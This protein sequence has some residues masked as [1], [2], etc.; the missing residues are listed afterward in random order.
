ML[1]G[2]VSALLITVQATAV[3]PSPPAAGPPGQ[4]VVGA[5]VH[6][7]LPTDP[8]QCVPAL[9][10]AFSFLTALA[11]WRNARNSGRAVEASRR[12]A[13]ANLL[14]V[15]MRDFAS[16]EFRKGITWFR[17]FRQ[18][19]RHRDGF[20]ADYVERQRNNDANADELDA[21]RRRLTN[22]FHSLSTFCEHD[23]LERR[24]VADAFGRYTLEF[25]VNVVDPIDQAHT[26]QILAQRH[27]DRSRRF[28]D[29]FL[30]DPTLFPPG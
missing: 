30:R 29:A 13:N 11:A 17:R 3:T 28:F 23:L 15:L 22:F 10:A 21:T 9:A 14:S 25:F 4:P 18:G 5:S 19:S 2:L 7:V 24:L 16:D 1:R 12:A 8:F 26:E 6:S 27:D 20:A